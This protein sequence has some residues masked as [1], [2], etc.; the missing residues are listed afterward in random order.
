MG[1]A[2]E[3]GRAYTRA[4]DLRLRTKTFTARLADTW[5]K[6]L[7]ELDLNPASGEPICR[8]VKKEHEHG[9]TTTGMNWLAPGEDPVVRTIILDDDTAAKRVTQCWAREKLANV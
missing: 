1:V 2:D 8:G 3:R 9:L 7:K 4:C 5:S 6:K